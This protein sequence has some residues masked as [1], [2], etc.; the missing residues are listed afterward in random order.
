MTTTRGCSV[1]IAVIT[2]VLGLLLSA[3]AAQA[4]VYY[5]SGTDGAWDTSAADNWSLATDG[6]LPFSWPGAGDA[7]F[8]LNGQSSTTITVNN[9]QTV[10]NI[11]FDGGGYTVTGGGLYLNVGN[12]VVNQNATINSAISGS[13]GLI[14]SGGGMLTLGGVNTYTGAMQITAGTL[15]IGVLPGA[16]AFV[17]GA[18]PVVHYTF[19]GQ[20]GTSPSGTNLP[21]SS[22]NGTDLYVRDS[23]AVFVPGNFGQ[24]AVNANGA[25]MYS[26]ASQTAPALQN[27]TAWTNSIWINIP[28]AN[29][30]NNQG[31]MST[32]WPD[33]N[34]FELSYQPGTGIYL[35]VSDG[36]SWV[37]YGYIPETIP[38]DS[39]QMITTTVSSAGLNLYVNGVLI[40]TEADLT[41]GSAWN[42]GTPLFMNPDSY[43]SF[44]YGQS[45][46][47]N[48]S[49]PVQEF[50]LFDTV[51]TQTQVLQLYDGQ[52][53]TVGALPV[54]DVQM[55]AG[56]LDLNG[57][58]TTVASLMTSTAAAASSP[59]AAP[60]RLPS[61]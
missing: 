17:T 41:Q 21:D 3:P 19:N 22:G 7:D 13:S 52:A 55:A 30:G 39:W 38:S 20:V 16:R 32:R 2:L 36:S 33:N 49:A 24:T 28:S 56:V 1:G 26:P 29:A 61:C 6:S 60:R 47:G 12:I 9:T 50:N 27:L 35:A 54:T 31:I 10:D 25:F 4:T 53:G 57:V 37:G 18:L 51:L 11:T 42:Y 45:V 59:I 48:L 46:P 34:G 44:G 14:V 40:G 15:Q 23:G 5:W 43:L 8:Y 58:T